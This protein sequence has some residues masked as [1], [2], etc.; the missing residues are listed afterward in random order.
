M[1]PAPG[2]GGGRSSRGTRCGSARRRCMSETEVADDRA[3]FVPTDDD[4][5]VG[6]AVSSH[7]L[8]ERGRRGGRMRPGSMQRLR[9]TRPLEELPL[10]R[11][12][13]AT[14]VHAAPS[15]ERGRHPRESRSRRLS[16][17]LM[18][19]SVTDP[20]TGSARRS[21]ALASS[22]AL[23]RR[24]GA[25]HADPRPIG[26][27]RSNGRTS[28]CSREVYVRASLRTYASYLGIDADK[29][30]EITRARRRRSSRSRPP[31]GSVAS[32]DDRGDPDPRQPAVPPGRGGVDPAGP[33]RVRAAVPGLGGAAGGADPRHHR[34]ADPGRPDDPRRAGRPRRHDDRGR[35]GRGDLHVQDPAGETIALDALERLEFRV[36]DAG[37]VEVSVNGRTGRRARGAPANTCS[38]RRRGGSPSS[39]G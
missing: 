24:G 2:R 37:L 18:A 21:G 38:P 5:L 19:G 36:G 14:D 1:Y 30:A 39:S 11:R 33:A 26:W 8:P 3:V 27:M 23:P 20:R 35:G 4:P 31:A 13:E 15:P 28:R 17:L 25:R 12:V 9:R 22:R 6:L 34:V 32:S 29:V 7:E 16:W 10:V